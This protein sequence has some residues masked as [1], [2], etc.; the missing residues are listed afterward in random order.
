M[1]SKRIHQYAFVLAL[2][3][4]SLF[5]PTPARADQAQNQ[6]GTVVIH[7]TGQATSMDNATGPSGS[8][9]LDL[10]GGV[11]ND[12]NGGLL[13]QNLTGILQIG[14]ANY[15]ISTGHGESNRLGR[16]VILGESSSGELILHGTI[17]NNSTMTTDSPPSR[18]SS[19]AY[20]ALS[21]SMSVNNTGNDS[22]VNVEL[23]Q[24]ATSTIENS[25][26]SNISA[27][28][29]SEITQY[30]SITSSIANATSQTEISTNTTTSALTKSIVNSTSL[31][32]T[33]SNAM[34]EQ[35][36]ITITTTQLNNQTITVYVTNTVANYT[37]TQATTTTVANITTQSSSSIIVSNSTVIVT[38]S[39]TSRP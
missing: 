21:G 20:L 18:L 4:V 7:L 9:T 29:T 35:N 16:F 34:P 12:G 26:N 1:K 17:Q 10:A 30:G 13:I 14:S 27:N 6:V 15:T 38:N 32:Q 3:A 33:V 37:I 23:S 31:N 25:T 28:S 8:A 11:H 24:N 2:L 19:L 39:T 5:S 36:S 22:G